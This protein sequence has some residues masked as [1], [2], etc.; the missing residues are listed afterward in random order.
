MELSVKGKLLLY[1]DDNVLIVSIAIQTVYLVNSDLESCNQW[2][3]ANKLSMH[4][5]ITECI[6]FGSERN[7]N[8]VKQNQN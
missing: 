7:I 2:F 4:V 6:L 1:A 5:G 3:T 8:K